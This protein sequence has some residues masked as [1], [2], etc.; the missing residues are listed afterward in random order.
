MKCKHVGLLICLW[1]PF[2]SMYIESKSKCSVIHH[3]DCSAHK[4]NKIVQVYKHS[5]KCW[6]KVDIF[7]SPCIC[8]LSI[9]Y[10]YINSFH[11]FYFIFCCISERIYR[12]YLN[13]NMV[14]GKLCSLVFYRFVCLCD[15]SLRIVLFCI[16][17]A[18][19][20]SKKENV[21]HHMFGSIR[22]LIF[23]DSCSKEMFG[24]RCID[25]EEC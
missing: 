18:Y 19:F 2:M 14:V 23:T 21:I 9:W 3:N 8:R 16:N 4:M 7:L 15:S 1:H 17:Q 11:V 20:S 5:C 13:L 25:S 24:L 22:S 12:W 6:K 10:T